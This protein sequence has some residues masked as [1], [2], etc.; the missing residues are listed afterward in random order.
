MNLQL[1]Q[2]FTKRVRPAEIAFRELDAPGEPLNVVRQGCQG[3]PA[4]AD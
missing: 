1:L 2:Y 3:M 4:K